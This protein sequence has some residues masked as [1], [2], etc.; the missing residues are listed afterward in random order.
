MKGGRFTGVVSRGVVAGLVGATAMAVWFLIIDGSQGAPF[1]TPAFIASSLLGLGSIQ[2][3]LGPIFFY[4]LVHYAAWVAVGVLVSWVLTQVE[5]ASPVLLGLVLG[6]ALFDLVFYGS[7]AMTGVDIVGELGWPEVLA[8]NLLAGVALMGFLHLAGATRPVTWW[9]A[10]GENRVIRE[11]IVSGLIGA[12]V[13]AAWF[14]IFDVVRGQPFFTPAALGSALF[15]G[16]DTLGA[17]EVSAATVVGYTVL[18]VTAFVLTGFLAAAIVAVAEYTPP[19]ILGAVLFFAAFEAFFM[20]TLAM[21]AEFLLGALAWWTIAGGNL[22]AAVF[23]G[24]YLWAKHPKLRAALADH[25]LD[26]SD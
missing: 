9:E 4:T 21:L 24:A 14:L 2:M 7:V 19:L 5:T 23:M 8:G 15:L 11:G 13:V 10:V 16:V 25:P 17:V 3:T 22:L 1:R 20:G 6:F 18:H 12:A 26:K